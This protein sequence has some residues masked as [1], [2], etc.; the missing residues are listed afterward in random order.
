MT[1]KVSEVVE[2][3]VEPAKAYIKTKKNQTS[4][5]IDI[6]SKV[7]LLACEIFAVWKILGGDGRELLPSSEPV[8]HEPNHIVINNYISTKEDSRNEVE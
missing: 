2:T 8:H 3:A 1:K 7:L 5:Q 4:S 6:V